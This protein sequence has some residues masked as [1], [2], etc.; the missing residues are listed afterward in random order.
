[1]ETLVFVCVFFFFKRESPENTD[2]FLCCGTS[3][4]DVRAA[5]TKL[6]VQTGTEEIVPKIEVRHEC[7]K[8]ITHS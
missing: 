4:Q 6:I 8:E 2:Q 5:V 3:Y 1:M 7:N